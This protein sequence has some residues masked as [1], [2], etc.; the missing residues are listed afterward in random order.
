MRN[1]RRLRLKAVALLLTFTMLLSLGGCSRESDTTWNVDTAQ[2]GNTT[3]FQAYYEPLTSDDITVEGD[4]YYA[5]SQILM[6]AA[7]DASYADINKLISDDGG[8]I[9]GYI[10]TTGDYQLRFSE[11]QTLEELEQLANDLKQNALV[12]EATLAYVAQLSNDAIDY[13]ND[14]WIDAY[15]SDDTSGSIWDED[16]PDG[17][18]WWAEAIRMPTV[19]S[20]DLSTE[21]VKVG[22]IDSMFDTANED[23]SEDVFEKTWNNPENDDGTCA[24]TQLY[25]DA[26]TAYKQA[27][28]DEEKAE[29]KNDM[30]SSSHGTH[31]AGIIAA[32]ANGFGIAGV[33]QNVKLYGY[34]LSSEE[35]ENS[36]E[37]VWSGV[38]QWECAIA[39]LLNEGVKVINIS[40]SFSD[41]LTGTQDGVSEY[42]TFTSVNSNALESFLLKYIEAGNEF[43]IVKAAGNDSTDKK[44]YDAGNDLLGYISNSRVK[45]RI[46]I[47][48]AAKYELSYYSAADFSNTGSRVD[49]YAPGVDILSDIPSNVTTVKDGTSMSTPI[50][51]GL[52]SLI[53][54]INPELSAEQ[55]KNLIVTSAVAADESSILQNLIYTLNDDPVAIVNADI[56]VQ[57]A[58]ETIGNGSATDTEYGT[59]SGMVYAITSDGSAFADIDIETLSLYNESGDLVET[60]SLQDYV[61]GFNNSEEDDN[62]ILL[63]TYSLLLGPGTYVLEADAEGYESQT[64]QVVVEA[65]DVIKA[66]FELVPEDSSSAGVSYARSDLS[67][68]R[69]IVLVLDVSGS[70][71]G[72]PIDETKK[73]SVNFIETI[74]EEDASI[75]IVTYD[76]YAYRGSDFSVSKESLENVVSNIS[77]GGGTNMEAGIMEAESMLSSGNAKKKI[78]VLMSD[79]YPNNGKQGDDLVEY[80]NQIKDSGV[81]IY[82]LGFFSDLGSEKS[83]AQTLMEKIASDGC[84]YEVSSADDLVF[85]FEDMADQINGQKYIYVRIACPVDVSVTYEGQTLSSAESDLNLRTDFGTLT[86]EESEETETADTDDEVKVLRLKEGTEYDIQ[87]VGTGDGSMDY[88][89]G[90][91]DDE[92]NYSDLRRFEDIEITEETVIDTVAETSEESILNIDKN[93]DGR[94]DLKLSAGENGY[95]EEIEEVKASYNYKKTSEPNYFVYIIIIIFG[96][97]VITVITVFVVMCMAYTKKKKR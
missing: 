89:I 32:K 55:V 28:S 30:S 95:G 35:A 88:T 94:Y 86:L 52:A 59:L 54:G 8:E 50:V 3:E 62:M 37:G 38:F 68:E 93:G 70:M 15:D 14:P 72:T 13:T 19:W 96:V 63:H 7:S 73:A 42:S 39:N 67:D 75:G 33:N 12:E 25:N 20:M 10:S 17:K 9:I 78:I 34:A 81:I 84:H 24:V 18:N 29:A 4:V 82:T 53:W 5:S 69:D 57:L 46:I 41:A 56:C 71:I 47:V 97:A 90:F 79:G 66:D 65:Y 51:A 6:T 2:S 27:T 21:T 64:Q 16:D 22:I 76:N 36:D 91:M 87:I 60:V 58:Q 11:F 83:S 49:V 1:N 61:L 77:A 74:L 45:N 31:V 85:F 48:G 92:G 80:A 44:K 43:L 23:L 40:R 26:V